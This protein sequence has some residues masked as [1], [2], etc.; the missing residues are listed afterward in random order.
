MGKALDRLHRDRSSC[1]RMKRA[2]AIPFLSALVGGGVVVA[3]IAALG[4]LGASQKTVTEIQQ[5][6][7]SPA[8]ASASSAGKATTASG[9]SA[10]EIY[11]RTAPGVVY[12][13]SN[14]VRQSASPFGFG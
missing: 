8:A 7:L 6:P 9:P 10:H 13:T 5:A 2:F 3:V 11:E 4:G 14:I 1:A 12:V